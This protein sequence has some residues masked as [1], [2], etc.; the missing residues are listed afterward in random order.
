MQGMPLMD[1]ITK[2]LAHIFFSAMFQDILLEILIGYSGHPCF[3]F[4]NL[5]S[6]GY[7]FTNIGASAD[8]S[9]SSTLT[10]CSLNTMSSKRGHG[11]IQPSSCHAVTASLCRA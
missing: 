1:E 10:N 2:S 3:S 4:L 5:S 7:C 6:I 11:P 8:S 9:K